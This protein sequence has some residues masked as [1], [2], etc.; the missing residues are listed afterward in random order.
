M[1]KRYLI[2]GANAGLGKETARQLATLPETEKIYLACRNPVRAEAAR[3]DLM[4]ITGRDLFEVVI[5][6]TTDVNSAKQVVSQLNE[7]I[8]AV[9]LNAGGMGGKTPEKSTPSGMNV[10]AATNILG[11]VALVDEL[12][13]AQKLNN[14]VL[15][16]SSE[17][18]R[19]IEKMN[20]H[21]PN[22]KTHSTEELAS[23]LNGAYFH[24]K[25]DAMQAYGH[26]KY[27]ATLWM[28]S[29][30]RKHPNIR[31]VSVSPGATSGTAA[32]NDLPAFSRFMFK[33]VMM[34]VIMPLRGMIHSLDKGAKRF[35][36]GLTDANAHESGKF[37]ASKADKLVGP[38]I[39]QGSLFADLNNVQ[40]QD[41]AYEAVHRF[42]A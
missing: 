7:A 29:M 26:V 22:L 16:A 13:A 32:P 27:V 2:T 25:F 14:V 10:L 33:Y 41:N 19:G 11:H 21:R 15:L 36:D 17:A 40:Y 6:D 38:V 8:D 24:P 9:V 4:Q 23:V 18:A 34:G 35:V 31:F 42:L 3:K 1:N 37:Y 39:D 12:I 5:F 30:A 20:M 28:S